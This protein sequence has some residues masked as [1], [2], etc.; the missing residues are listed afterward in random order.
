MRAYVI[1]CVILFYK[2]LITLLCFT[3]IVMNKQRAMTRKQY[4]ELDVCLWLVTDKNTTIVLFGIYMHPNYNTGGSGRVLASSAGGPGFNP[5]SRT[6][7]Y[8]RRFKKWYQVVSL[9]STED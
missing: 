6:A 5:Q 3:C 9:F 1:H 4:S 2:K 8:Q 7:S